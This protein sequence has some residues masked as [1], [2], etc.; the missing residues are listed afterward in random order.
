VG[1]PMIDIEQ[2]KT[3]LRGYGL[4]ANGRIRKRCFHPV[5]IEITDK[6]AVHIIPAERTWVRLV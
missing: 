2:T 3:T 1:K 6:E 5:H 4:Y